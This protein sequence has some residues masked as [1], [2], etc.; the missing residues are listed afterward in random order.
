MENP[1]IIELT[2]EI[3]KAY[4][5]K[6][7][8]LDWLL[9]EKENPGDLLRIFQKFLK[10]EL[11]KQDVF[12]PNIS[13]YVSKNLHP[14]QFKIYSGVKSKIYDYAEGRRCFEDSL[15]DTV[16]EIAKSY[17]FPE[18]IPSLNTIRDLTY[19]GHNA[20][21][22][23][24]GYKEAM[25]CYDKVIYWGLALDD[26][27]NELE[28]E[29]IS[30]LYNASYI[31]YINNKNINDALRFAKLMTDMVNSDNY[32]NPV[33]R[34]EAHTFYAKLLWTCNERS[35]ALYFFKEA[36]RNIENA[37]Q[38]EL[39][40][41]ALWNVISV[42]FAEDQELSPLCIDTFDMLINLI[43][44]NRK[45]VSTD[46]FNN[47]LL[48][49]NSLLSAANQTLVQTNTDLA[50]RVAMQQEIICEQARKLS[51]K[52]LACSCVMATGRLMMYAYAILTPK[53]KNS[54]NI[55]DSFVTRGAMIA[56]TI[57]RNYTV[58]S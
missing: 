51:T 21:Y 53:T 17:M 37:N 27:S 30:A 45:L 15:T 33:I 7:D 42:C 6:K 44:T 39:L 10:D 54:I 55:K 23:P 57:F 32:Y 8:F 40:M 3:I 52:E 50:E 22:S 43:Q 34:Y 36:V 9:M 47:L 29:I 1:I 18:G 41:L 12:L 2:D 24:Y 49:H 58:S 26:I 5:Q 46:Y 35:G 19:I 13:F 56:N 31:S 11:S 25:S 38:P 48:L 28:D 14:S 16:A 4:T 20:L